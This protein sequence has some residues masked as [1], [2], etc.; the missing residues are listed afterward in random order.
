[1]N[2]KENE[3]LISAEP[4]RG[5]HSPVLRVLIAVCYLGAPTAAVAFFAALLSYTS[6]GMG[7]DKM[8]VSVIALV[9]FIAI[10]IIMSAVDKRRE[11]AYEAERR[12]LYDSADKF[13]GTVT[14]CEKHTRIIIY[15]NRKYEDVT[16]LFNVTFENENGD[17][18]TVKSGRYLNDIS[19]VL[20]DTGADVL[21]LSNGEYIVEGLKT[22]GENTVKLDIAEIEDE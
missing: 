5:E 11:K 16:W 14:G 6:N 21:R 9:V 18:V 2:N 4:E 17:T 13:A 8:A 10:I 19:A 3:R 22:D 1:M 7:M 12:A 15:A 20:T